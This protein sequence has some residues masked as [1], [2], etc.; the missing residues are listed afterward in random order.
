MCNE[1]NNDLFKKMGNPLIL[2]EFLQEGFKNGSSLCQDYA[3]E[4]LVILMGMYNLEYNNYY[5][6]LYDMIRQRNSYTLKILKILEI[7]LKNSKLTSTTVFPFIKLF[8]RKSLFGNPL[9]I[10]WFLGLVI[11]L[12]KVNDS[13][14]TFFESE[15]E[16]EDIYDVS[17][18]FD[19]VK[20][21]ELKG[22]EILSLRK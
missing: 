8:L 11:N 7:S 21:M 10:C 18:P 19:E 2:A 4:S 15:E 9:E 5:E 13:L 16:I 14:R 1:I 22:F 12:S 20:D 6:H 17:F 3:L